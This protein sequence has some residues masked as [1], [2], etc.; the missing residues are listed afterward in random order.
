[1][2]TVGNAQVKIW[3]E[4]QLHWDMYTLAFELF[5]FQWHEKKVTTR[6][7]CVEEA[8]HLEKAGILNLELVS[9]S[10]KNTL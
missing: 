7:N 4:S 6:E 1:M 10:Y 8:V 3:I 9:N 5:L 2:L